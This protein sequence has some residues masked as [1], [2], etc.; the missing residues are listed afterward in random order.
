[1][2][3][4]E[5]MFTVEQISIENVHHFAGV[6]CSDVHLYHKLVFV[7]YD[8]MVNFSYEYEYKCTSLVTSD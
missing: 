2:F 8:L 7:I 5:I 6:T 3:A 4:P 1:M